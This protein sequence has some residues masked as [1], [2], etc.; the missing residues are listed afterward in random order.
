[1][2]YDKKQAGAL[3]LK[4]LAGT[5]II[6]SAL[7]DMNITAEDDRQLYELILEAK[8]ASAKVIQRY[9]NI[10]KGSINA[11][12]LSTIYDECNRAVDWKLKK[13]IGL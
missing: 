12:L 9:D 11:E 7:I 10:I 5:D 8:Q 6:D 1:M 13:I 3:M 2:T 4:V